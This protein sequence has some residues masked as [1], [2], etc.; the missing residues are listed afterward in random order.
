MRMPR[1]LLHIILFTL[2]V[3]SLPVLILGWYSYYN[4][5]QAV[6]DKVNESTIQLLRQNMHRV[7]Q[8]LMTGDNSI[9]QFLSLHAV[10]KAYADVLQPADFEIVREMMESLANIQRFDLGVLDVYMYSLEH[11]WVISNSGLSNAP[12]PKLTE[13]LKYYA[14]EPLGT[15][16]TS[17]TFMDI[18]SLNESSVMGQPTIFYFKKWPINSIKPRGM[19]G[20]VWSGKKV[21]EWI[22]SETMLGRM[23]ILNEAGKVIAHSDTN[24]I[25]EDWSDYSFYKMINNQRAKEGFLNESLDRVEQ[26]IVYRKSD[27]N[28]WIYVSSIP[29]NELTGQAKA[30]RWTSIFVSVSVLIVIILAAYIGSRR[31]YSPIHR[32]IE[33]L[34]SRQNELQFRL[35]GQQRQVF[36][37]FKRK[38]LLGEAKPS[39]IQERLAEFAYALKW[40]SMRVLIVEIDELEGTP[41][42]EKDRD[43]LDY[44]ISNIAAEMV[45][46]EHSLPPAIMQNCVVMIV[47]D[48]NQTETLFKSFVLDVSTAIQSSV[49]R[50]LKLKIS[51]GISR[52]FSDWNDTRKGFVEGG[53]ALRYRARL[54]G[55][56]ILFIEDLQPESSQEAYYPKESADAFIDAVKSLDTERALSMLSA[57]IQELSSSSSDHIDYQLSLVRFFMEFIR[58]LQD[59]G[60]SI[61]ALN[62]QEA[63]LFKELLELKHAKEM[64][65][66]FQTRLLKP[67]MVLLEERRNGQFRTISEEV[68]RM[69]EEA[70]DTDLTLE[71]CALRINYHPQ[72]I[73]RVFRRETGVNFA[74]YLAQ[75]RLEMAKKFLRDSDLTIKELAE[76]LKYNNPANF[77]R[78]F[79][80]MEGMTPG[81]YRE[82]TAR[83]L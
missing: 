46:K 50:Y 23:A 34:L 51:V 53:N 27:Y 25:G 81:Q 61:Q 9:T 63:D 6:Q 55:E 69:I 28:G 37:L 45:Q 24:R 79:R 18:Q 82:K 8:A 2:I 38:L 47:G 78:Y 58:L 35:D 75:H 13:M 31:M 44:A 17:G 42:S 70:Y 26:A 64:E 39:D 71:K 68:K 16:W 4:S 66:W 32:T 65:H 12:D 77:I 5:S 48:R 1:Y 67:S 41:Y 62:G 72:Y 15:Y 20:V 3:G 60:I 80:K 22:S 54:G 36:E 83:Q 76:R 10:S 49:K 56:S 30:I 73:S 33:S 74:D 11:D 7:E 29:K 40:A 52:S 21:S 19:I 43:L 57:F 14:S 59:N